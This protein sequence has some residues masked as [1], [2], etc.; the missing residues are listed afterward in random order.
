MKKATKILTLILV[1]VFAVSMFV[2]CDLVGRDVKAYRN[3]PA[4]KIGSQYI[5][6]GKL[7]DTFN[8]Y[9]NNYYYYISSGYLDA[10]QLLNMAVS[11]LVQQYMQIDDYIENHSKLSDV[12]DLQKTVT[13]AEYITK[14]QFAYAVKYVN[15]LAFSAF[16]QYTDENI[17]SK[18]DLEEAPAD[19]TSRDFSEY[20]KLTDLLG[21]PV[22]SYA[23]Y[24]RD[25]NFVNEDANK[26]FDDNYPYLVDGS[27]DDE[28]SGKLLVSKYVYDVN[29][30]V[31]K[32]QAEKRVASYNDRRADDE[33]HVLTLDEYIEILQATSKQYEESVS[34]NYGLALEDFLMGQLGDMVNS[35]LLANWSYE[36]YKDL[37]NDADLKAKLTENY[38]ILKNE[39]QTS[40]GINGNFDSFI[41]SLST[42]S[43]LYNVP[44]GEADKYVF[45]KNI[46]VPFTGAQTTLLTNLQNQ[47]GGTDREEYIAKRNQFAAD[48]V[49]E[50]FKS[51]KYD[52]TTEALF[53]TANTLTEKAGE[54]DDDKSQWYVKNKLFSYTGGELSVSADGLLGKW[55]QNGVV[56]P[57]SGKSKTDT[58]VELMKRFNTDT[59]QHTAAF[60]YVVYVGDDWETYSHSW[61]KEFYTATNELVSY[62]KE[63]P[64]ALKDYTL[65]V[66]TY[67]VHIIYLS[68]NISDKVFDE[69]KF[70]DRLK[71]DT[72]SYQLFKSYFETQMTLKTDDAFKALQ[73]KNLKDDYTKYVSVLP[74]FDK[75]A[76]DNEFKFDF[77]EFIADIVAEL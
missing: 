36:C 46:L 52:E 30:P 56:T 21:N 15:Y 12:T 66:S 57:M 9:Y 41:T 70:E 14:D 58:V 27:G 23:Q 40:F 17:S 63:H 1:V 77:D 61:V 76:A 45:V 35:C 74:G 31:Q 3:A 50:Y 20:D 16:D 11:S 65:C 44:E 5:T 29:D 75:F 69:F 24:V 72:Q 43:V 47:L 8:S 25:Q 34:N 48:I 71:T 4:L 73:T 18:M 19:D 53:D 33:E 54:T 26:Y 13:N 28:V 62:N 42:S 10:S 68:G 7:L 38:N 59:A 39:Q 64:D 60:D 37:E 55:L 67:G 51:D 32:A 49:A 6:V 2:G 22:T